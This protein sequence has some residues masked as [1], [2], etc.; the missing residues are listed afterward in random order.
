MTRTGTAVRARVSG[1][2]YAVAAA[3]AA[4]V[5]ATLTV[6]PTRAAPMKASWAALIAS[7]SSLGGGD[8]VT[9][10]GLGTAADLK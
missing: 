1:A 4:S 10:R 3:S 6:G 2:P 7:A 8:A 5:S 9:G